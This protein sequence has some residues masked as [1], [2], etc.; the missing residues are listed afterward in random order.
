MIGRYRPS[1]ANPRLGSGASAVAGAPAAGCDER[2][3]VD[4]LETVDPDDVAVD[5]RDGHHVQA[6]GVGRSGELVANTRRGREGGP[7]GW[8]VRVDRSARCSQVSSSSRSPTPIPESASAK[9]SAST[10]SA[11]A[12]WRGLGT[13]AGADHTDLGVAGRRRGRALSQPASDGVVRRGVGLSSPSRSI[14]MSRDLVERAGTT[15]CTRCRATATAPPGRPRCATRPQRAVATPGVE[16]DRPVS[17]RSGGGGHAPFCPAGGR[18]VRS[19]PTA[20]GCRPA[21]V[22]ALALDLEGR[23]VTVP[24]SRLPSCR[25]AR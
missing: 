11:R 12:R 25:S 13:S 23:L 8:V 9:S 3:A 16:E 2:G 5:G 19:P 17:G 1:S 10:T 22:E 18:G 7:R 15:R 21:E 4:G 24:S 20:A 6:D 14:S